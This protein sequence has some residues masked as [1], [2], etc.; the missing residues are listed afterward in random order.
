MKILMPVMR[1]VRMPRAGVTMAVIVAR[2]GVTTLRLS[3]MVKTSIQVRDTTLII[4]R[5]LN[6]CKLR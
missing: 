5:T 1:V 6:N 4:F 3:Q 2:A